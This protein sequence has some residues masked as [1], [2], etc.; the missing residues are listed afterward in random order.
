MKIICVEEHIIDHDI[1]QATMPALIQRAGYTKDWGYV[2]NGAANRK[3]RQSHSTAIAL[4]LYL[5]PPSG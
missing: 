2:P 3:L 5:G 4:I 1:V